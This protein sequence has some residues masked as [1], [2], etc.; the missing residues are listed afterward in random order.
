VTFSRG[1]NDTSIERPAVVMS[2][3]GQ[4]TRI[5]VP[6]AV[7]KYFSTFGDNVAETFPIPDGLLLHVGGWKEVGAG[8]YRVTSKGATRVW[9][10]AD[11]PGGKCSARSLSVSPDACHAAFVPTEYPETV[12]VVSLCAE[13]RK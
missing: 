7:K 6:D 8:L 1:P 10:D 12:H 9:C 4:V 5:L 11:N 13:P 2:P 3:D